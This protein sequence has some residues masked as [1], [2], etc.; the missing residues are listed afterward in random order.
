MKQTQSEEVLHYL[1]LSSEVEA[2]MATRLFSA[3]QILRRIILEKREYIVGRR[4]L[5]FCSHGSFVLGTAVNIP[6]V[7]L[8]DGLFIDAERFPEPTEDPS[9]IHNRVCDALL[10]SGIS[11]TN[12]EVRDS[13]VRVR[14]KE[15]EQ[16][17]IPVFLQTRHYLYF[18]HAQRGWQTADP[19]AFEN[20]VRAQFYKNRDTRSIVR[21]LKLWKKLL[22]IESLDSHTLT[23]LVCRAMPAR[24]ENLL[25]C[26]FKVSRKLYLSLKG[27]FRCY[28]PTTPVDEDLLSRRS[29]AEQ[30][31]ILRQFEL[32]LDAISQIQFDRY[33]VGGVPLANMMDRWAQGKICEILGRASRI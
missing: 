2:E 18:G 23:V 25:D 15:D 16:I 5:T 12:I 14:V 22:R 13:C 7:D 24:Y 4:A 6:P 10:A 17:D 11:L 32:L 21:L 30:Q 3:R 26:L 33:R 29:C 19:R 8:D 1:L 9:E 31:E 27:D 20:W 28:R